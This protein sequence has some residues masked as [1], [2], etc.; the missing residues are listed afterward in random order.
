MFVHIR[1]KASVAM[2]SGSGLQFANTGSWVVS[3]DANRSTSSGLNLVLRVWRIY[4]Q[5][6]QSHLSIIFMDSASA[7][8]FRLPAR[9][10]A[11]TEMSLSMYH[12]Q[13]YLFRL[14]R[15]GDTVPPIL[16]MYAVEEVLSV[17]NRT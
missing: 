14:F 3:R 8:L 16:L 10:C 15:A 5:S 13:N 4:G 11:C 12:S 2:A 7:V 9:C 1:V 17:F 6:F